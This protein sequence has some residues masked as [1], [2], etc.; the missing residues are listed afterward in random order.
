[1]V[2]HHDHSVAIV[3]TAGGVLSPAPSG[4]PQAD[5]YRP[6]RLPVILVG[7]YHL[8]GIGTTTSV[9]EALRLRGYDVLLHMIFMEP[10][11]MNSEYLESY[12]DDRGIPTLSLMKPPK[13]AQDQEQDNDA[14]W[15]YY[16]NTSSMDKVH[17][18]L[19]RLLNKH[20]TRLED[21]QSMP[22]KANKTIWY[23]FTQHKK[24]DSKDIM[25]IDS[26]YDD[27]FD[28]HVSSGPASTDSHLQPAF[29][30]SASWWTQGLGHGN[31]QLALAAAY[32][33]GR[34]G[35]VMFAGT[36]HQP[37]LDLAQSLLDG[38]ENPNLA[39]VFYS[40][41]GSTGVEVA[42]KMALRASC[43]RYKWDHHKDDIEIL[44]LKG[45]Y[46][47]DTMGVMD[48]AEPST[49]NEKVEWYEPKGCKFHVSISNIIVLTSIV[50]WFDYPKVQMVKGTW[51][52][53]IPPELKERISSPPSFTSLSELFNT[54][55]FDSS[56]GL[57]KSY[58]SSIT[59]TLTSLRD[60]GRKF[61]ALIL[62]PV[63]LGAGGMILM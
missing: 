28:V 61:G 52:L 44:G 51:E 57:Y 32:A 36:I 24:L 8:G 20:K 27:T 1:M 23:P 17:E 55:R 34:Y 40:D 5:L 21:L 45:S 48:C 2:K 43:S 18:H 13:P 49:Y 53:S 59:S 62:E 63:V 3:E 29:D 41:N 10:E 42:V 7:D 31:P 60:S 9:Y 35:H 26:A 37:A 19:E 11:Y 39:K 56:S 46:H 12:F 25:V 16:S 50:D 6:L 38:H 4:S 30:A 15:S 14:M 47:G 33:A 22:E 54:K 58:E